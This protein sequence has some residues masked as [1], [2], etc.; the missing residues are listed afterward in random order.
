MHHSQHLTFPYFRAGLY[1]LGRPPRHGCAK[2]V[3][4]LFPAMLILA[5]AAVYHVV[6]CAFAIRPRLSNYPGCMGV[7]FTL[8]SACQEVGRYLPIGLGH[9]L[10]TFVRLSVDFER[11]LDF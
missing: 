8:A 9:G 3:A 7:D 11:K 1:V 2:H 4:P 10:T 6:A 5:G